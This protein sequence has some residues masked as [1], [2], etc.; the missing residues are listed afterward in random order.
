MQ[1]L[2]PVDVKV[3]NITYINDVQLPPELNV[4]DSKVKSIN[5]KIE[6]KISTKV[7]YNSENTQCKCNICVELVPDPKVNFGATIIVAGIF[8]YSN[9][10]P[11]KE[12]HIAACK[13]LFPYAQ[14]TTHSFMNMVGF[15]NFMIKEPQIDSESIL[16][17]SE[18]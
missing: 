16:E 13:A 7:E 4:N 12:L 17:K 2:L 11:R 15:P 9:D 5:I 1:E 14:A 18:D 6:T 8:N 3:E 10:I